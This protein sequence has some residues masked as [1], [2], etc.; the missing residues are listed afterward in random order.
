MANAKSQPTP[1]RSILVALPAGPGTLLID[2]VASLPLVDRP[3]LALLRAMSWFARLRASWRARAR[4]RLLR[5]AHRARSLVQA[6]TYSTFSTRPAV[7]EIASEA[8][9]MG[10]ELIV[11]G[12]DKLPSA[13][14]L[15]RT[16]R[17][18]VLVAQGRCAGHYRRPLISVDFNGDTLALMTFTLRLLAHPRPPLTFVH[19]HCTPFEAI[20]S[21]I[22]SWDRLQRQLERFVARAQLQLPTGD[23]APWTYQLHDGDPRCVIPRVAD[24]L[25]CDLLVLGTRAR[26]RVLRALTGSVGAD[27]ARAVGCDVLFVPQSVGF[28]RED[29]G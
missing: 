2:R 25:D 27:A 10:T 3:R 28:E 20:G 24:E 11:I 22:E 21:P 26:R 1:L 29:V 6:D 9:M 4:A 18:P 16:T 17:L 14:S 7:L 15:I 8:R 19:A 5:D 13:P 12:R 23:E